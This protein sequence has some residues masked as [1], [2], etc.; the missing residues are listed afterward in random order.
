M[1]TIIII[2]AIIIV[3]GAYYLFMQSQKNAAV[4]DV[5]TPAEVVVPTV[6]EG[7]TPPTENPPTTSTIDATTSQSGIT[8]H[9]DVGMEYPIMDEGI[10]LQ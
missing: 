4:P 3:L 6:R 1:R 7:Y 5:V 2:Q 10:E 9:S 8:G